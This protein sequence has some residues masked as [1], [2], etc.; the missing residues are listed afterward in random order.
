MLKISIYEL[1]PYET[2]IAE[3]DSASI[4]VAVTISLQLGKLQL[5]A[6]WLI[7]TLFDHS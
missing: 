3:M 4:A 2:V 6:V 1:T 7:V 5:K